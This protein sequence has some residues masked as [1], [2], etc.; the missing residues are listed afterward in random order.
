[1]NEENK[2]LA[3]IKTSHSSVYVCS[4]VEFE[5]ADAW[6]ELGDLAEFVEFNY[7][8]DAVAPHL[9]YKYCACFERVA[10]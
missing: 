4:D 7:F 9:G 1:M 2:K 10:K 3:V 5:E 6:A 8:D